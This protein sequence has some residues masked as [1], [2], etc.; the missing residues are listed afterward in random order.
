MDTFHDSTATSESN[1][2]VDPYVYTNNDHAGATTTSL[3]STNRESSTSTPDDS[4]HLT[5]NMS[6]VSPY[7]SNWRTDSEDATH[8][9][10]VVRN[11][12]AWS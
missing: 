11:A 1:Y 4:A 3:I 7:G 5:T 9:R 6:H 10:G 2:G 12:T 8:V